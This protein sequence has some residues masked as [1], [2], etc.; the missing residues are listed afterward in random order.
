MKFD[1]IQNNNEFI[2]VAVGITNLKKLYVIRTNFTNMTITQLPSTALDEILIETL[3]SSSTE[4]N[5]ISVVG[6]WLFYSYTKPSY[7]FSYL[8]SSESSSAGSVITKIN[9]VSLTYINDILIMYKKLNGEVSIYLL[10]TVVNY[11][12]NKDY[13]V[14]YSM[15]KTFDD[16]CFTKVNNDST[17]GGTFCV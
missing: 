9:N 17:N 7:L 4:I 2:L 13:I 14:I 5:F 1:V 16:S 6:N 15:F 12:N 8:F 3:A 11:L 10:A